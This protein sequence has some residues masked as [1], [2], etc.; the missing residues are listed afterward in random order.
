MGTEPRS[1]TS[2]SR[3]AA[4]MRRGLVMV[5]LGV[6]T[7]YGLEVADDVLMRRLAGAANEPIAEIVE[8]PVEAPRAPAS[9]SEGPGNGWL[10]RSVYALDEVSEI[11]AEVSHQ[12][13]IDGKAVTLRGEY[14]QYGGG[15]SRQF[16]LGLTGDLA[17]HP[18]RMLRVSNGLD[19]WTDIAFDDGASEPVRTLSR[20]NLR[21][22]KRALN[23]RG[24]ASANDP[25]AWS[26]FGGLPMLLGGLERD[27]AFG[28]PRRMELRGETV[29]AMVGRWRSEQ[30]ASAESSERAPDHVVVALSEATLFPRLVEYRDRSDALLAAAASDDGLLKPSRRPMLK[31]ELTPEPN[32]PPIDPRMFDYRSS[33]EGWIDRTD[34]ELRLAR[35]DDASPR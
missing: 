14:R 19:L 28:R 12:G 24:Q 13:W 8:L 15:A 31:I 17:G 35:G 26:R 33:E 9:S 18:A 1:P 34:R 32:A 16:L 29:L 7:F 5:G 10:R 23:E 11:S 6:A 2:P 27:F 3:S 30:G 20:I 22:V 25:L 21:D 4:W